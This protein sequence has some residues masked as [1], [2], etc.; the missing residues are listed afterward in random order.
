MRTEPTSQVRASGHP[1]HSGGKQRV[2][3]Q[4]HKPPPLAAIPFTQE[5]SNSFWAN[6]AGIRLWPL[7]PSLRKKAMRTEP[8]SQVPASGDYPLHSGR[9]QRVLSQRHKSP[10]LATIPFTQEESSAYW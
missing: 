7:S 8:T 6:V 5:E 2:L 3:S 4:R 1:F 10:P 9:K